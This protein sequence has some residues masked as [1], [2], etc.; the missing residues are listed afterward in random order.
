MAFNTN[1]TQLFFHVGPEEY[2][3][4]PERSS[5]PIHVQRTAGSLTH[6]THRA[7]QATSLQRGLSFRGQPT[8]DLESKRHPGY[9]SNSDVLSI[10]WNFKQNF[11]LEKTKNTECVLC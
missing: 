9:S 10:Y 11:I 4:A 7:R 5:L 8:R 6:S 1:K 3:D 2:P